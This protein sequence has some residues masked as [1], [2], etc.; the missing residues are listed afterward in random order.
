MAV[1]SAVKKIFKKT[2]FTVFFL[3]SMLLCEY[4]I[5]N[6]R[7]RGVKVCFVSRGFLIQHSKE[8]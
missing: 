4:N 7:K 6:S 8:G 2:V 5:S 3:W 1:V